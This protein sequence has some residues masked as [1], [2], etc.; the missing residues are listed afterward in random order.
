MNIF[1]L[2]ANLEKSAQFHFDTHVVKMIL[3]S[4]QL[5]STAHHVLGDGGPYKKT[6][7]NHPCAVWV[8]ESKSNY[9]Y[10]WHLMKFLGEEYQYRFNRTHKTIHD[11]L[12]NL[13]TPPINLIE[14][15]LTPAPV[16]MPNEYIV[17]NSLVESYRNYYRI[18][19]IHL[20]KYTKRE[21]P[22]WI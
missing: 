14:K 9:I 17:K 7:E 5:L 15:A 10:L 3:E 13:Y 11:H 19:K 12:E 21:I 18:G 20:M 2:D 4:A 8:R 6:H 16:C 22:Q 1:H